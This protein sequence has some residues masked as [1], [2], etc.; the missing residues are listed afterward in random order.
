MFKTF[1]LLFEADIIHGLNYKHINSDIERT[2][3][4]IWDNVVSFRAFHDHWRPFGANL[5][6]FGPFRIISD[7]LGKRLNVLPVDHC[8][9]LFFCFFYLETNNFIL[10]APDGRDGGEKST[11]Q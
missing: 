9:P 2:T 4:L 6:H 3:M 1:H 7:H 8:R 5:D 10:S 11:L